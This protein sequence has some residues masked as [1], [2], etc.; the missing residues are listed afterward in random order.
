VAR[1]RPKSV[2]L[3]GVPM[4]WKAVVRTLIVSLVAVLGVGV[5]GVGPVSAQTGQP[6]VTGNTIT[7]GGVAG[8]TNPVGQPYGSGFDGVQAYFN[9]INAKGGVFGKKFKLVAQL[10]DQSRASQ[11][12]T[13]IRSLVEEK[14]VFAVAPV[15]TQIFAGAPY[16]V[17]HGVP[18]FGWNI[19]GEWNLGPNLFGE[20][21]SY[22]CFTCPQEAPAYLAQ[23]VGAKNVA[24]MAYTAPQ[25][26]QCAQGMEAGFKRYGLNVVLNDSSL[27]FGFQD[28][29]S[30]I[31]TMKSKGVQFV[32]TCMDVGG[33][34]NVARS[35]RRAGLSNVKFYAPQGYDPTTLAKYGKE[36]D[37]IYFGIDFIPF[38]TPNVSP[39]LK[40]FE[41]Q[42]KKTGKQINEQALA[43]WIDADMLYKGI[44]A[45]GP[46]FTQKSVI[47]A[48]NS[49]NGYTADDIR[50]P[51]NWS[52]DGHGPPAAGTLGNLPDFG[53]ETCAAYVEAING[54]YVPKFGTK[55]QPFVCSQNN[56]LPTALDS[57]SLYLRPAKPG[58]SLPTTATVPST[59][60]AQP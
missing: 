16:L 46:N 11:N 6:G 8:K 54:K 24:I 29:G 2:D 12:V 23:Q 55:A 40:L 57:S 41:T 21:G 9:Y 36:L 42:M 1:V 53:H 5:A 31:D 58:E 20:K 22:L 59:A 51:V 4:G 27:A 45:A 49:F 19:N 18:T 28:L 35:L 52:F 34:V 32:G 26:V 3:G 43:G 60:P 39:G 56:P 25:S 50:P 15:V 10:D 7:V 33:E 38:E 37:G 47:D 14:K 48:V 17:Q 13:E 44:K 30:D